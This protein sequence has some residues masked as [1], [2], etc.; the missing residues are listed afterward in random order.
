MFFH[1]QHKK[2]KSLCNEW[3]NIP[4]IHFVHV[5]VLF[6]FVCD[7]CPVC[8]LALVLSSTPKKKILVRLLD[9][10]FYEILSEI[11]KSYE[12][13]TKFCTCVDKILLNCI[14]SI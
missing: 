8:S 4:V 7:N 13:L 14:F 10:M 9:K 12:H 6:Q 3:P 11:V 5:A 1:P 2:M